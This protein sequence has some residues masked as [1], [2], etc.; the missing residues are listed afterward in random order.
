MVRFS[1][2]SSRSFWVTKQ[3]D[4]LYLLQFAY[5]EKSYRKERVIAHVVDSGADNKHALQPGSTVPENIYTG[6]F[7][8]CVEVLGHYVNMF[9][10]T[11][12]E[13]RFVPV[14]PIEVDRSD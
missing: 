14:T 5:P 6:T 2:T 9:G 3:R 10:G 11:G 12:I 8:D 1:Q 7:A 4:P 13:F